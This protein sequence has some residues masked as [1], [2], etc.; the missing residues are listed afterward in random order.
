MASTDNCA[1]FAQRL[2]IKASKADSVREAAE[3]LGENYAAVLVKGGIA[4]A[5]NT[6]TGITLAGGDAHAFANIH[7]VA[8]NIDAHQTIRKVIV[9]QND[10]E[11]AP[12][13][14]QFRGMRS[15]THALLINSRQMSEI[16]SK[17]PNGQLVGIVG[18]MKRKDPHS[19]INATPTSDRK[20]SRV[21]HCA[22][23][24]AVG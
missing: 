24:Q 11:N 4:C 3:S 13:I 23:L 21:R 14:F 16:I 10:R 8:A 22:A 5:A 20:Y 19:G 12:S 18:A 1:I 9:T 17:Y 2:I 7:P 6:P 15:S